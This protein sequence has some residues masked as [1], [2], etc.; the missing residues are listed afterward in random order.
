VRSRRRAISSLKALS[1]LTHAKAEV[2]CV[3]LAL[4]LLDISWEAYHDPKG[5]ETES[6]YVIYHPYLDCLLYLS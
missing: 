2:F 3:D 5:L 1:Q 4:S 6:G